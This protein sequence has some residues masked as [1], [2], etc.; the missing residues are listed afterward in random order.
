[1]GTKY[2]ET[3]TESIDRET[4][5]VEVTSRVQTFKSVS[6]PSFV[7]MYVDDVSNLNKLSNTA[8]NL[9]LS[10]VRRLGYDSVITLHKQAKQEICREMGIK[11]TQTIENK[12]SELLKSGIIK[13]VC[14]GSFM[15]NP[16]YFAK[17]QWNDVN[18]LRD[19]YK[20]TMTVTYDNHGKKVESNLSSKDSIEDQKTVDAAI[21]AID[22]IVADKAALNG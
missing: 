14:R 5:E 1:M 6:E 15:L 21:L 4:G 2:K 9:L 8:K 3:R 12:L 11:A 22:K 17:G 19:A 18:K 13:R 7:K 10:L 20:L 16:D